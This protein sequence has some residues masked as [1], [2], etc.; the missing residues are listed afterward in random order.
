MSLLTLPNE[1]LCH[2]VSYLDIVSRVNFGYAHVYL[3]SVS[4]YQQAGQQARLDQSD[5]SIPEMKAVMKRAEHWSRWFVIL[6]MKLAFM[7]NGNLDSCQFKHSRLPLFMGQYE[8]DVQ[9]FR[10]HPVMV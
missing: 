8:V 5:Y 9:V 7:L 3:M 2:I 6:Q 1:L 10:K 4:N